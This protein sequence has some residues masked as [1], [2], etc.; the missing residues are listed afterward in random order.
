[1]MRDEAVAAIQQQL[2]F[3]SDQS[4]NII[5][6]MKLAQTLLESEPTKPWFMISEQ[7]Y[8]RTTVGEERIP[9]PDTPTAQ[10]RFIQEIDQARFV[11][12]PEPGVEDT[13]PVDLLKDDYDLLAKQY[14]GADAGPPEAYAL[15]G[16][17]F[18]VFPTP[19]ALYQIKMIFIVA[20]QTLDT[21]VENN[22]LKYAPLFI[23]GRAGW[24]TA[25]ALRDSWAVGVFQQWE[26]QGRLLIFNQTEARDHANRTYQIGGPH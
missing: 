11:Y 3:R 18:H 24:F 1:M 16:H 25:S 8:I 6:N 5:T 10:G 22:W 26:A 9:L 12:I 21:N 2:G 7:H 15:L 17:Y 23:M 4:A 20:Q 14:A 13:D 19:D